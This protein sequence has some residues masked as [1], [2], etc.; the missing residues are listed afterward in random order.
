M[1]FKG[2]KLS[3]ENPSQPFQ[4]KIHDKSNP[5]ARNKGCD[6]SYHREIVRSLI[7]VGSKLDRRTSEI[8]QVLLAVFQAFFFFFF[9]FSEVSRFRRAPT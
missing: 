3:D 6:V 9:F 2:E 5:S 8:S 1:G 4:I 7:A